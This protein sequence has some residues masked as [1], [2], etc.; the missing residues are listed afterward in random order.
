M[1][2]YT[3]T[4]QPTSP[5]IAATRRRG[6]YAPRPTADGWLKANVATVVAIA[7]PAL[8]IGGIGYIVLSLMA[9]LAEWTR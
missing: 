2:R 4:D 1:S 5:G 9:A 3:T 6:S 7:I 8:T